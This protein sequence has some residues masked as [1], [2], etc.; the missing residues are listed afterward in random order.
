VKGIVQEP[1]ITCVDVNHYMLPMMHIMMGIGNTLLDNF[2]D[3]LDR[4]PGLE[5]VPQDIHKARRMLYMALG[6]KLDHE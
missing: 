3:F 6:K 1:L 5:N 4:V 2:L